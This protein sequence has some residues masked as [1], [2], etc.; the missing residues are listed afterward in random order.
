MNADIIIHDFQISPLNMKFIIICVICYNEKL[1]GISYFYIHL[2]ISTTYIS[3]PNIQQSFLLANTI[4]YDF[5]SQT[6][7]CLFF[8][9]RQVRKI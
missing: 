6:K 7:E 9:L 2:N 1:S 8:R 5:I 3:K 4:L